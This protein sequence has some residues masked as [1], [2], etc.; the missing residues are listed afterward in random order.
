MSKRPQPPVHGHADESIVVIVKKSNNSG[1]SAVLIAVLLVLGAVWILKGG[2]SKAAVPSNTESA[3]S[4][5]QGKS[6]RVK[7]TGPTKTSDVIPASSRTSSS[8]A[9]SSGRATFF[10]PTVDEDAAPDAP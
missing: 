6:T 10:E 8:A 4:A 1:I 7:P 2:Q 5:E 3:K 9:P